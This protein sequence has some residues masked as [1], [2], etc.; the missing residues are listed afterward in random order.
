MPTT[1]MDDTW[2]SDIGALLAELAEVQTALLVTLSEKRL[3][4][5]AGDHAALTAM[6]EREQEL[7]NRLQ[8]CHERRQQLL[9][10]ASEDG[11]PADSIHSLSHRLP[12]KS[13]DRVQ[14]SI[15]DANGRTKILQHQSLANWVLVQRSLL[16]LSQLIEIIATGG[17]PKPTY[18]KG[19]DDQ[20]S[21]ALVD[22]A[23]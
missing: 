16:H 15:R 23:A 6:G 12:A 20:A 14:A 22:R 5:A 11:L 13:R 3:L 1:L 2:E 17:R 10:R 4:L 9:A 7:A 21:G 18:G 8:A 19:S